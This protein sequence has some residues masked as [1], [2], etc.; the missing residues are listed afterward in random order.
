MTGSILITRDREYQN[1]PLALKP[2]GLWYAAGL[3]WINWCESEQPD[4]LKPR[5]FKLEMD[6]SDILQLRTVAETIAFNDRYS[7][8]VRGLHSF[9]DWDA[10]KRDYK[11]IE[12]VPYH[13]E[14]RYSGGIWY[15]GL[16]VPSGCLWDLSA[17]RKTP[18]IRP[19]EIEQMVQYE[20]AVGD[21]DIYA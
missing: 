1:Q 13:W 17:L 6:T 15:Y 4:W 19:H 2:T 7:Q 12:I 5:L 18:L 3:S 8:Q 10:V 21:D 9:I 14:L 20:N 16:D 11:G